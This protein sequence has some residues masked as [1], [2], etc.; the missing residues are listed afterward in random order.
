MSQKNK[1]QRPVPRRPEAEQPEAGGRGQVRQAPGAGSL[2][3]RLGKL[4][5]LAW[6]NMWRNKVRSLITSAALVSGLTLMIGMLA[7]WE[8]LARQMSGFATDISIGHLQLQREEFIANQDMYAL[9]PAELL[10]RLSA[11]PTLDFAPRLYSAGL[12]SVGDYSSGAFIKAIDQSREQ[13]VTL[14]HRHVRQGALDLGAPKMV[15]PGGPQ[16]EPVPAFPVVIGSRLARNLKVSLGAELVLITQAADGSIGNGLFEVRGV[17]SPVDPAFDRMGVLMSLEAYR[18]LMAQESGVHE[19]A[20]RTADITRLVEARERILATVNAWPELAG[21]EA[22]G[23]GKV[24][25]RTWEEIN[26]ALSQMLGSYDAI[27]VIFAAIIFSVAVLGMVN[28][29][30]MAIHERRREMG[31]LLALG[32]G[33]GSMVSMVMLESLFLAL[34]SAL[35]GSG[36]GVA[37]SIW[38]QEVGID[39]GGYM[40]EGMD[41]MGVIFE[42]VTKGYLL[43]EHVGYSV[44]IMLV[45]S[46]LAALFPSLRTIRLKPALVLHQ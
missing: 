13:K 30:L 34:F 31:V 6:R 36:T 46:M 19:L 35:V 37:L 16:S 22:D 15:Q 2:L 43:P 9:I 12:V 38:L 29:M 45:I 40:P 8:G 7:L 17:L 10:E 27:M 44:T 39:W 24:M 18:Y 4:A 28:T 3:R 5:F 25:V 32:M 21:V 42:P 20:V 23:G 1:E 11:D 41:F 26:P 33:R 14:L